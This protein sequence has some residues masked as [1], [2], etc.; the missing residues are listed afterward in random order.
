MKY[1]IRTFSLVFLVVLCGFAESSLPAGRKALPMFD[2]AKM[3]YPLTKEWC[4]GG[5]TTVVI[6]KPFVPEPVQI[7][8]D[9]AIFTGRAEL[10]FFYG[11]D[12]KPV[13]ARNKTFFK[14]KIPMVEF[15]WNDDGVEYHLEIF[16]NDL[17]G[18]GV[19]N[20]VQFAKISMRNASGTDKTAQIAAGLRGSG[21][22]YRKNKPKPIP[23]E[24]VFSI[25]DGAVKRDGR[26]CYAF[27][28]GSS[29]FVFPDVPYAKPYTASEYEITNRVATAFAV[30][31]RTLKPGESFSAVF[32]MPRVPV[33]NEKQMAEIKNAD[34]AENRG[35]V[36]AYWNNLFK[37]CGF[38]IPEKRVDDTYR[39]ALINLILATRGDNGGGR[40]QGSG[41]PYGR[42]FLNDYMDM[43]LAYV[44][45]GLGTFHLP[46]VDWLLKKQY[47]TGMFI[48]VHNRGNDNIVTSHGQALFAL[49]YP[50]L[51]NLDKAYAEKVYPAV[52]K[53]VE[54]I[55][56]DHESGKYHG[57]LRPSIPYDA[58]MVTGLH[59][60]HNLMAL[61]GMRAAIR[62]AD[63]IGEKEDASR[64]RRVEKTYVKAIN[65]A[66][67]DAIKRA[68]YIT[69]GLYDWKAGRVQG[70]GPPN[71]RPNQDWE[72]MLLAYPSEFI[73]PE[74]PRL[75]LTLASI[76]GRKY[77]EGCMSYRN[78]MH[79]HQY[80]TLNMAHQYLVM[81][82]GKHALL[83]FYHVLLHNGPTGEG[84]ENLVEPWTNR[85]PRS[86]CPPPHAWAAAKTALFIRNMLVL[87]YGGNFGIERGK[88]DLRLYSLISPVW[89]E[90]G[91]HI[92]INAIP[93][94]FGRI[95]SR[96]D[97]N[98]S[99]A[100]ISFEGDFSLKPRYLAIRIPYFVKNVTFETDDIKAFRENGWI[101][102]SPDAT[103][104]KLTWKK[105]PDVFK[106]NFQNILKSYRSEF[107]L[108]KDNYIVNEHSFDPENAGKP[109]LTAEEEKHPPE[110]LS[111]VLVRNAFLEEYTRR[112]KEYLASGRKPWVVA[113]PKL[114]NADERANLYRAYRKTV[115]RRE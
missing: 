95:T 99:G 110:P 44:R 69:S 90:P 12:L 66:C 13:M 30:Y 88:R 76:R 107:D 6:G 20:L 59:S 42:L 84:F 67:D 106:D 35:M 108:R 104:L 52:K 21:E 55:V 62:M 86:N 60:C 50:Y 83:D 28:K 15:S 8:F 5:E 93:T 68:G 63:M 7:T 96:M 79:I 43:M 114:L 54:L 48:D 91:K 1:G 111:F 38:H 51:L 3:D 45:N 72:N 101:Y 113:P 4:Y 97:F 17:P 11:L 56:K 71:T 26:L 75:S 115:K 10:A 77:R 78:G 81:G 37:N 25:E 102:I 16:S 89:A 29:V 24:S 98:D 103:K 14:G 2:P 19:A 53:G 85:T 82:D 109:F 34:Y 36:V 18:M 58:P 32:K 61:A 65:A 80:I 112:F 46:N 27:S 9:G 105:N 70:H 49:A 94:E 92:E 40:R 47:R 41:L 64:W 100:Q 57:L 31:K 22:E 23:G 87:E 74:D 33:R 73:S 39:E